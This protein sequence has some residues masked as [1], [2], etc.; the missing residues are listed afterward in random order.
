MNEATEGSDA[1]P[2]PV[3]EVVGV[4]PTASALETAVEQLELAGV[5]RAAISVLGVNGPPTGR[6]DALYRS[7]KVIEDDPTV[8]QAAFVSKGTRA[9]GEAVAISF[10]GLIGGFGGAWAVAASGG[11]LVTAIGATILGGAIGAGLGALLV[12]AVARHHATYIQSQLTS[13]GLVLWVRTPDAAAELG[14]LDILRRCG[15]TS[16][17]THT[18]ERK[19]GVENTPLHDIQLDPFLESDKR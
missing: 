2:Y 3:R 16:V 13:G 8:R 14:A 7:A 9:E 15:G 10:P 11:A 4:F 5:S 1:I 12:V 17:H 18:I 19:W 6:I